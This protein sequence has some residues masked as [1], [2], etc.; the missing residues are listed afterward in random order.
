M[1][2]VIDMICFQDRTSKEGVKS[3]RDD[4]ER[5]AGAFGYLESHFRNA[6]SMDMQS[7]TLTMLCHLLTV[8]YCFLFII[9]HFTIFY[10]ILTK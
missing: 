3:A 7:E 5:A 4:F 8:R 10:S 6:P 1:N 9:Y 2:I